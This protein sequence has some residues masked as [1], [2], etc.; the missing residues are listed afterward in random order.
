MKTMQ[1]FSNAQAAGN[2][3]LRVFDWDKAAKLISER[4]PQAASA[5][6]S[7]DW[8][9]TGGQIWADG[10]PDLESYT[11]LASNWAIPELEIDGE[12]IPCFRMQGE[13]EGWH[14]GTKWPESALLIVNGGAS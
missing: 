14:S 9:W 3:E 10:K 8:E 7:Q 5:G 11:Y 12:T 13:T 2:C 6:L 1:A 4:K